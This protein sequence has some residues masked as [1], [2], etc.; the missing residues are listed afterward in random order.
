M[1]AARVVFLHAAPMK[2]Y[3]FEPVALTM[4]GSQGKAFGVL[5][6]VIQPPT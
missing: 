4:S 2:F 1:L 6:G 3:G 5:G